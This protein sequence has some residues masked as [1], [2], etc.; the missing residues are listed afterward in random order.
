M[1]E[2]KIAERLMAHARLCR[3]LAAASLDENVGANFMRMADECLQAA[4]GTISPA[5]APRAIAIRGRERNS[6]FDT[7]D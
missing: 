7:T 1:A 2:S 3:K 6:R 4:T 5:P